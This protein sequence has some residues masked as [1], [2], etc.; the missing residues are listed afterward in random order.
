MPVVVHLCI[1]RLW[2]RV[3]VIDIKAGSWV[4]IAC[5]VRMVLL[6]AVIQD[7]DHNATPCEA[8]GPGF[9]HI[10]VSL[11]DP[12]QVPLLRELGVCGLLIHIPLGPL[13]GYLLLQP[14]YLRLPL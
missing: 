4:I 3:L 10:Q 11:S 1:P 5:Q 13:L 8:L 2:V 7:G 14:L 6:N 12:R 9:L